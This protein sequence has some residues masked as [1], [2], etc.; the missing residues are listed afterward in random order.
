MRLY[1]ILNTNSPVTWMNQG[2][3]ECGY[4]STHVNFNDYAAIVAGWLNDAIKRDK[5][6]SS[7][8]KRLNV[9]NS[10]LHS[11]LVTD[12][13]IMSILFNV[14]KLNDDQIKMVTDYFKANFKK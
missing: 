10:E 14:N 4:F 9:P 7:I 1:E 12:H 2:N 8:L 3:F 6:Y 11:G 13:G 5:V